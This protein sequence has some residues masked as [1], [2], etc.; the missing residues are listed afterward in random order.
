[1]AQRTRARAGV[2]SRWPRRRLGAKSFQCTL[3]DCCPKV[4]QRAP[5]RT[6][7]LFPICHFPICHILFPISQV[8]C[9]TLSCF[10]SGCGPQCDRGRTP[11]RLV[12]AARIASRPCRWMRSAS[13][14]LCCDQ[15]RVTLYGAAADDTFQFCLT[16]QRTTL[17]LLVGRGGDDPAQ[18]PMCITFEG[19]VLDGPKP[20]RTYGVEMATGSSRSRWWTRRSG[21]CTRRPRGDAR[22]AAVCV[23]RAFP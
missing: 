16:K 6:R 2:A 20:F 13:P 7:L 23:Q 1:M 17:E 3:T 9:P 14:L 4:L 19:E 11:A 21:N 5:V 8:L 22:M 12:C 15:A 18:Q 10:P